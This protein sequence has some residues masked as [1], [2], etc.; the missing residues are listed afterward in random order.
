M[1]TLQVQTAKHSE[2]PKLNQ[3]KLYFVYC[4][5]IKDIIMLHILVSMKGKIIKLNAI[6]RVKRFGWMPHSFDKG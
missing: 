6:F 3:I 2:L 1:L 4:N 5:C